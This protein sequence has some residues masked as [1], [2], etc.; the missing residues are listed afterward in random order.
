[1]AEIDRKAHTVTKAQMVE[2]VRDVTGLGWTES[3]D[4]LEAVL[5]S[6]KETLESGEN[7]KISGFGTFLVRSKSPRRGRNPQTA[8][9]IVIPKRKVLTFKPS[10]VL[11]QALNPDGIDGVDEDS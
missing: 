4:L 1:M 2:R 9:A 3:G 5:E 7:I 11:R 10:Q 6:M 8:A